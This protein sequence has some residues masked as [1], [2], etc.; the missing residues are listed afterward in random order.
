MEEIWEANFVLRFSIEERAVSISDSRMMPWFSSDG[1]GFY[2]G[3]PTF[4]LIFPTLACYCLSIFI[5]KFITTIILILHSIYTHL[6]SHYIADK[7]MTL[8]LLV[9]DRLEGELKTK[10]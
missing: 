6:F 10:K 4:F 5:T 8:L 7:T 3:L 2:L 9:W 1:L